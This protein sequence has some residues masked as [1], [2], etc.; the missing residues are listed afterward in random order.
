[1]SGHAR[2]YQRRNHEG[3]ILD[4]GDPGERC[5]IHVNP[6]PDV[7][8]TRRI[9]LIKAERELLTLWIL[10]EHLDISDIG[11]T[12]IADALEVIRL[13]LEVK[14]HDYGMPVQAEAAA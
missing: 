1:M 4:Y 3:V 8:D 7:S 9:A 5:V 13:G 2:A 12:R 6:R 14:R 11:R 10:A